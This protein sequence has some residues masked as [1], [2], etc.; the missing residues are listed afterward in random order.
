[1][2][3]IGGCAS[4]QRKHSTAFATMPATHYFVTTVDV[5]CDDFEPEYTRKFFR[6]KEAMEA[7]LLTLDYEEVHSWGFCNPWPK[8]LDDEFQF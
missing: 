1:V 3:G 6:T 4:V 2:T 5:H 8:R 7:Y